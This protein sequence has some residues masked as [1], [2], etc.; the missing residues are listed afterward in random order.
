MSAVGLA[1]H[2]DGVLCLA[3]LA[4]AQSILSG[5]EVHQYLNFFSRFLQRL[6][7]S[8]FLQDGT[9][10]IWDP[11]T[12]KGIRCLSG[13]HGEPVTSI[14]VA[15][16]NYHVWASAGSQVLFSSMRFYFCITFHDCNYLFCTRHFYSTCDAQ[17][18]C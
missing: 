3:A 5:S 15:A 2:K 11:N 14:A 16:N 6:T 7:L 4:D 12:R 18:S 8:S 10:R 1:G 9:V 17:R 13:F